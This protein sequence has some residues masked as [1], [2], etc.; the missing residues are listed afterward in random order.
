MTATRRVALVSDSVE[1]AGAERY[2]ETLVA[3]LSD[4]YRF[5]AVLPSAAAPETARRLSEAGADIVVVAGLG[6]RPSPVTLSR[7][8]ATLRRIAPDVIHLNA[9]DQGDCLTAFTVMPLLRGPAVATL[10]NAIPGRQPAR[11]RLSR[12]ALGRVDRVIAVSG[13][14]GAWCRK[15]RLHYEVVHNGV[16]RPE[17]DHGA[18]EELGLRAGPVV[19]GI[20]RLHH[21]KA[22]E[23]LCDAAP[24]VAAAVAGVQ[25]VVVGD[26]PDRPSLEASPG[27]VRFA[28]Y[29]ERASRLLGAFDVLA[30]PSRFESFGLVAVEAMWAGVPIVAS[31][32]DGLVEVIG[33][34]GILVPPGRSEAL[35]GALIEVLTEPRRRD[36]LVAAGLARAPRF[37]VEAMAAGTDAVYRSVA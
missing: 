10:H 30:L 37:S 12:I 26:G 34:A 11:E 32:V 18:R 16:P 3:G 9:T 20:G 14:I 36:A 21:Q 31:A 33:E 8:L 7:L 35:A 27:G 28:G 19:G 24:R 4:R 2:L 13:S 25:F 6:R 23:V 1:F 22:W 5:I 15:G 29:R 17:L